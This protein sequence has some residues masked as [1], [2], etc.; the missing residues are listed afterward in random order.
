MTRTPL[1]PGRDAAPQ[2]R[3]VWLSL[4]GLIALVVIGG[5]TLYGLSHNRTQTQ[6]PISTDSALIKLSAPARRRAPASLRV[7][8]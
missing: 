1:P 2:R 3:V 7:T 6:R 8:P 5:L 4:V